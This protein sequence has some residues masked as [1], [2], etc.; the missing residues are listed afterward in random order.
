[1]AE[2][3][4][5]CTDR[6]RVMANFRDRA[7]EWE[8]NSWIGR[9]R[10][11]D[12]RAFQWLLDRYRDRVVRLASHVLRR[13]AEA[14]D[15]AQEAFIKAFRSL[16]SFRGDGRFYTWLYHIVLRICLDRR[17]LARWDSE[18]AVM[19]DSLCS[20]RIEDSSDPRILVDSL[21]KQLPPTM[22]ATLVLRELEGM[23]YE[24]IARTLAIPVGTVRSRLHAARAQFRDLWTAAQEEAASV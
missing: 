22:R 13:P 20:P 3:V 12:P 5:R 6:V 7:D 17:R 19:D 18:V 23:E 8:E 4:S 24:E 2:A 15:V 9:A 21:M 10:M 1:M 14:E 16:G 11:S